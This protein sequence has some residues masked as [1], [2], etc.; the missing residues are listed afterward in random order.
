MDVLLARRDGSRRLWV[1]FEVSRADP[2]ANHAKFATAHLFRPQS[3]VDVFLS[4]M[5]PHVDRGR[6]NLA[7]N[8]ISLMR[9]VGMNAFQT[10]L[11]PHVSVADIKRLNHLDKISLKNERLN[12]QNEIQRAISVTESV[13]TDSGRRVHLVGNL[14]EAMLNLRQWNIELTTENGRALWGRRTITYFVFNPLS[15]SFAPSK[16]CAYLNIPPMVRSGALNS[17]DEIRA[18]M[19]VAFYVTLDGVDS[20]FDGNKART[21][22]IKNLGMSHISGSSISPLLPY[23]DTWLTQHKSSIN[24]HPSGPV[25]LT[26][27]NWFVRQPS[28]L[29]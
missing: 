3:D 13:L 23:F 9:Y 4:M 12:V 21:H 7:A 24:V 25:F 5:S 1:E 18:E 20:R 22:L 17:L 29:I 27:P 16:F 11:L 26:P 14:L 28:A 2:V 19:T 8:T 15:K 6:Q 10:L